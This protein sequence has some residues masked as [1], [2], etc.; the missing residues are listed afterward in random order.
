MERIARYSDRTEKAESVKFITNPE[1]AECVTFYGCS[2]SVENILH[3]LD[4]FRAIKKHMEC[5][6]A[7]RKSMQI[8]TLLY[9]TNTKA[10]AVN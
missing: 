3:Q 1:K 6:D 4:M 5:Q 8:I 7:N 2:D 10:L 9:F